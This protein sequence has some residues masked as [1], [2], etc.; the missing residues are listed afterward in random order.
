MLQ[1]RTTMESPAPSEI[2]VGTP[3]PPPQP[4]ICQ[5]REN[6]PVED[7]LCQD[8]G[9]AAG[10]N[11]R[12]SYPMAEN[13]RTSPE[14]HSRKLKTAPKQ[15]EEY[16]KPLKRLKMIHLEKDFDQRLASED[17]DEQL[18]EEIKTQA[19]IES[20]AKSFSIENILGKS[21]S[22][23]KSSQV[24]IVRPWDLDQLS[25]AQGT[26]TDLERLHQHFKTQLTEHV[27]NKQFELSLAAKVYQQQTTNFQQFPP[28][29]SPHQQFRLN[30]FE[31]QQQMLLQQQY[32]LLR[33][34][35]QYAAGQSLDFPVIPGLPGLS[36]LGFGN[37]SIAPGQINSETGSDR[38]SSV[39]S[40]E[41]CSPELGQKL[42]GAKGKDDGKGDGKSAGH[43]GQSGSN[44]DQKGTP[45]D[46]L[47]Q[48]TSKT[49]DENAAENSQGRKIL[50][51]NN[52]VTIAIYGYTEL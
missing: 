43:P 17:E 51:F 3:S 16:F 21:D 36:G 42:S 13:L 39:N 22:G 52:H 18:Q 23:N 48:M 8:Y 37:F 1:N 28:Q 35:Q 2:S 46:A 40:N 27:K 30:P 29:F 50:I 47:F 33:L 45:L 9:A 32:Q 20:T 34:N 49:F 6:S 15:Q 44:Q 19:Q 25:N 41:C 11:S 5:N 7:R 14:S 10:E 26:N 38:S 31:I 4:E 24:K 12:E